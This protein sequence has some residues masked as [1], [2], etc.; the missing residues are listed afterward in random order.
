MEIRRYTYIDVHYDE[1]E[2]KYADREGERLIKNGYELQVRDD[3]GK[4]K[5]TGIGFDYTDQYLKWHKYSMETKI[6]F[7]KL[8]DGT[9]VITVKGKNI[10]G[11]TYLRQEIIKESAVFDALKSKIV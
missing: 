7:E 4:D 5:D 10:H 2:Q 6:T 3:G 1:N 8:R 11:K 9:C